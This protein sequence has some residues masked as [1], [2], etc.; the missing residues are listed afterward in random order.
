MQFGE[1]PEACD[2]QNQRPTRLNTLGYAFQVALDITGPFTLK[3]V[4]IT[5][6]AQKEVPEPCRG[7]APADLRGITLCDNPFTYSANA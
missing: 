3:R 5:A 2:T 1:A 6:N 4:I 7:T